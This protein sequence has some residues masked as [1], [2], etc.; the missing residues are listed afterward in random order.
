VLQSQR[1]GSAAVRKSQHPLSSSNRPTILGVRLDEAR[2]S[3]QRGQRLIGRGDA[4]FGRCVLPRSSRKQPERWVDR[5]IVPCCR[6]GIGR[7]VTSAIA[8]SQAPALKWPCAEGEGKGQDTDGTNLT[9]LARGAGQAA[10]EPGADRGCFRQTYFGRRASA[11]LSRD[12]LPGHL[13][14]REF[15]PRP[16]A[17]GDAPAAAG[18]CAVDEQPLIV[19]S[20]AGSGGLEG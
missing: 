1:T 2:P 19:E 6:P 8:R 11:R 7:S 9:G 17:C 13:A 15:V 5:W 16:S 18:R 12:D 4:H 14:R 20:G 10:V 3:A